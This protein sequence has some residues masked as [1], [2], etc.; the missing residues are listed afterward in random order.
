MKGFGVATISVTT[1]SRAAAF[2]GCVLI[3]LGA[4]PV[5]AA[6][7]LARGD[8][9][10]ADRA[11]GER[12]GIPDPGA[13]RE[14]VAAYETFLGA[15]PESLEARWK[16]LRALHFAGDFAERDEAEKRRLFDRSLE[17]AE[18]GLDRLARSL[19]SGSRVEDLDPE[20]L[21]SRLASADV[22]RDDVARLHFWSAICWGAW[23]RE[24]GLIGAVRKG[25][26]GKLHRYVRVTLAL[27]PDYDEGGALR[28]L[29]RLHAALPRVPLMSGWVD[30]D[31]ALPLI[32]QAYALAPDNPGNQLLLGLTLL[33]LAP[34]RRRQAID[35]LTRVSTSE[36]RESMRIEDLAVREQARSR[37]A[38]I[39]NAASGQAT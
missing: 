7:D 27:E 35:L 39:A 31:R 5:A 16:L 11:R 4:L 36:P 22:S 10:W 12:D 1:A 30:R 17:V 19:G 24:A 26:G 37:L 20:I 2:L 38:G 3:L 32:E 14:A 29:G 23:S 34:A 18:T 28:L 25:V 33:D 21:A 9:A 15:H 13:I 6:D 8:A